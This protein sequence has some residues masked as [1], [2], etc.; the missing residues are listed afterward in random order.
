MFCT[1][2]GLISQTGLIKMTSFQTSSPQEEAAS[3]LHSSYSSVSNK[4]KKNECM[5]NGTKSDAAR[6]DHFSEAAVPQHFWY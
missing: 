1:S 4:K 5:L 6:Q 2:E 3:S